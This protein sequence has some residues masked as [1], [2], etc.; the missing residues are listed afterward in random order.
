MPKGLTRNSS[1]IQISAS[2]AES[3]ANTFTT[4]EIDLTLNALDQEV[5]VVTQVNLDVAAPDIVADILSTPHRSAVTC[6][7]STTGRSDVGS[8]ANSNVIAQ[9]RREIETQVVEI[10]AP[11][12]IGSIATAVFDREDP[13]F[14]PTTEEYIGIIATS[15][16]HLNLQGSGNLSPKN[17]DVRVYGYRAKMDAAG[18]AALVQSQVL[19][20]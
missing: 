20:S 18:Y 19:S 13:L 5:F 3:V 2:I 4:V 12:V 6:T 10:G 11:P 16:C 1:P 15:N 7:L 17:A 14:S 8:I 9:G